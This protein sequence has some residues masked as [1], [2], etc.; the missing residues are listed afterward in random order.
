MMRC[1][2]CHRDVTFRTAGGFVE[3]PA[4][5]ERYPLVENAIPVFLENAAAAESAYG[6]V[7]REGAAS[8]DADWRIDPAHG[9]WVLD[10]LLI[11]EPAIL[12]HAGEPMLEIGAGTGHLT[13]TLAASG[14]VPYSTLWVTDLSAEMLTVNWRRR[15]AEE[16]DK[17]VRYMVC[18]VLR[19]PAPDATI[20]V[21]FGFDILH[22][23]LD[24]TR[25]LAE[26]QRLLRPGGVCVLKEPHRG[27]YVFLRFLAR[28]LVRTRSRSGLFGR[29]S[30][31]DRTRL[32]EWERHA[33]RLMELHDAGDHSGLGNVDDKYFFDPKRLRNEACALG[34][35]RFSECNVLFREAERIP[36][37]PMFVDHFRGLGLSAAGL[38]HVAE[39]GAEVDAT[40]GQLLLEHAPIN[41]LF[42]FWK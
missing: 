29:L 11:L 25:G 22:H 35:R 13:R 26:I 2:R 32:E 12:E 41:T 40:F 9:R 21:V 1:V 28:L 4:C 38:D 17:D 27:A 7:F 20:G 23:V 14:H 36:Y 24:Y 5:E 31:H 15:T 30:R 18:N 19:V 8:Y 33:H 34:F 16:R 39:I 37:A 42:L 6:S 10:R 3:C